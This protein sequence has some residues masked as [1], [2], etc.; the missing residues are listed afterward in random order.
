MAVYIVACELRHPDHDYAPF[1]AA[2]GTYDSTQLLEGIHLVDAPTD[3]ETLRRHLAALA[4]PDDRIWVSRL[5]EEH[6]GYVMAPAADW[7]D[8]RRPL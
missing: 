7:L 2:L 6:S 1:E 5:T 8:N 4:A 3:V